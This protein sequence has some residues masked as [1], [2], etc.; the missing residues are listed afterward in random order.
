MIMRELILNPELC[1][2]CGKC[3]RDC[4][5]NAI[6]VTE[7]IPLFCMH[8]DPNRAPCLLACPEGA[9]EELGGAIIINEDKC[10]GCG[11]C[12]GVCPIGAI[13]MD[14]VGLAKKCNLCYDKDSQACV[15]AC[16]TKALTNDSSEI[17][18]ERQEK[19]S[20]GLVKIQSIMK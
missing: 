6:H 14:E 9:I 18:H 20:E 13:N 8:C 2:D 5:N 19:V 15:A 12:A 16:P 17:I 3:E 4:P 7:G 10:I 1:V 11:T